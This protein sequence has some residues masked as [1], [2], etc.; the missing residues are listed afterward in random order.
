MCFPVKFAKFLR[1]HFSTEHHLAASEIKEVF[2]SQRFLLWLCSFLF[3]TCGFNP[4]F[5]VF[6]WRL[7][8]IRQRTVSFALVRIFQILWLL[9]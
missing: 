9:N 5:I 8:G 7:K 2:N 1:T 6:K 3:Q 4:N